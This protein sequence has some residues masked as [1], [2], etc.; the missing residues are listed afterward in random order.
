MFCTFFIKSSS[1]LVSIIKRTGFEVQL[2]AG[3]PVRGLL[4]LAF[5][6]PFYRRR[7]SRTVF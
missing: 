1:I 3:E 6:P 5:K 7:F 4:R 2:A